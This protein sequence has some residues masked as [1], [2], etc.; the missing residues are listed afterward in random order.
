VSKPQA[1]KSPRTAVS[2]TGVADKGG[3]ERADGAND[4]DCLH[5]DCQLCHL[6]PGLVAL[7]R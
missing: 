7:L 1:V 2:S 5:N 6:L 3:R 4:L